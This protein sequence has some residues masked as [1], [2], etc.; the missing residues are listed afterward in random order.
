LLSEMVQGT[1][2][3]D[4]ISFSAT[5]RACEKGGAWHM[6][7]YLLSQM[8]MARIAADVIS[9]ST[10]ISACELGGQSQMAP[11]LFAQMDQC[12]QPALC[13]S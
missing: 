13:K 3:P 2:A 10:G 6:A 1:V 5:I 11:Y 8:P 12:E 4:L 9:V 7:L